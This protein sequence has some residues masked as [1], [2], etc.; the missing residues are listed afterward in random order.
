VSELTPRRA[1][2][3]DGPVLNA[4]ARAAYGIY[5]PLIGREPMPMAVDWT[6]L[7]QTQE[8]WIVDG[9]SGEAVASL[10]LALE[11]DHLVIWSI[12]VA[13]A[14]QGRGIGRDLMA[15]AE[16]RARALQRSGIRLFTNARMER[17]I[18][19]YRRLGY[20][21][22]HREPLEDGAL[23]HMRKPI[24][25]DLPALRRWFA[26]ELR[27]AAPVR[28]N[29]SVVAAF[30]AVPR[31]RFLGPGPWRILPP[32]SLDAAYTT[33]DADPHWLYHDVLVVID[34]S[35][36][37]NNGEPAL[38]A[39]LFDRLDLRPGERVLQV[40]AGTGY[41]TA[42][43]AEIV[44]P[45]GR[46]IAAEYHADLALRTR[47]NLAPW[48]Q[49]QVVAG[50]GA[51]HDPGEVDAV[52]AFAGATHP[53]P[54]WLE[55]LREGGRLLMPLTAE[56]SRGFM[57]HAVRCGA[58]FEAGSLGPCG[59]F[60]CLGGRDVE[61]ADCLLRALLR[62]RGA[63]IPVRSLHRGAPPARAGRRVWYAGPGFWLSTVPL[64]SDV[65]PS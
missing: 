38:W 8:V 45:A 19:R 55:R 30:A 60:R 35:R 63:P 7:L 1:A 43:L 9:P 64:K 17:N 36:D 58:A 23:V 65:A 34:P 16:T 41:Y 29:E 20:L 50:D 49:V 11:P 40:G 33:P 27:A 51:A 13:P 3:D 28:R 31:E 25:P 52:I 6:T 2:A 61:A 53:A 42:I 48:P 24:M 37:I 26:E 54:L 47:E 62:L 21:E 39:R 4:L 15:F 46:V 22:T 18:A 10:A 44:G 56:S 32:K 59:F 12:A 14:H 5:V 57:L